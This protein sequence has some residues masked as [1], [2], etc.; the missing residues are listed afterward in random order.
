[1]MGLAIII[2][3]VSVVLLLAPLPWP[4][5]DTVGWCGVLLAA[6]LAVLSLL[7]VTV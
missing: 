1:M 4:N 2:A 6:V 5:K 7:H 3:I